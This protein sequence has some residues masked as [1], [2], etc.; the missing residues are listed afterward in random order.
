MLF[1]VFATASLFAAQAAATIWYAGVAIS[2]GEFGVYSATATK[3]T[4]IP[5]R[6]GAE[7]Q[8]INKAAIDV[9]VDQNKVNLFR[10][11]FL[12]ERMC[13][14]AYGLGSKF[15]ETYF[16]EFADAVNYITVTKGA[17]CILDPHNYMRYNDPS[18]QPMT[19]SVI[20]NASD[21]TAATTA[22]FGAFWGELAGR[23]KNNEKAIFGLMNEPHDMET[24][25][26]LKNDQAAIDAIRAT[27]AKQLILA[28]G[29]GW[30]GGHAWT[31]AYAG[32]SPSS[33]EVMFQITDPMNNTAF[34]IHEYL[35]EDFSGTHA[36]CSQPAASNLA[37]VTSWLQKYGYKAMITE[38]GASNGTQCATYLTDMVKYMAANDVYIGWTAW[39]AGPLW[40]TYSPCCADSRLW[41]SL[42]PGS[43]A[44]DG[45]PGLYQTVWQK[46]IQPLLPTTLQKT[47]I[48]NVKGPGGIVGPIATSK[49]SSTKTAT[50]TSSGTKT[51]SSPT[52]PTSTSS[53]KPTSSSAPLYGQC[54]GTG[55]SGP[56]TAPCAAGTCKFVNEYYSQCV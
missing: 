2:G 26:V 41:G 5:G 50:S 47:G 37:G 16:Q 49:S 6:L 32:N 42:E 35:D 20:G 11:A 10:V 51:T 38:F 12:L 21:V 52:K 31:G 25:L 56:W 48:S 34:D 9:Y 23:F 22:Q 7:Y 30:T 33:S 24:N 4:G 39:A 44:S 45:S 1:N 55:S 15:N 40:G 8:F 19:G 14:L 46:L 28:P 43:V 27:G 17:Y 18:Q 13:P 53:T 3:G 29:N 54:G 36:L